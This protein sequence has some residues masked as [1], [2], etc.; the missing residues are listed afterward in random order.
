[1]KVLLENIHLQR[2]E[3]LKLRK[4]YIGSSEIGTIC[5]LNPYSSPLQLWR[6][7]T[8]RDSPREDNDFLWLGRRMEPVIG[9]LFEKRT[10]IKVEAA[11]TLYK[12]DSIEFASA[13]PDF[14]IDNRTAIVETKNRA[15]SQK[16]KYLDGAAPYTDHLQLNWQLGVCGLKSGYVAALVGASP[17]DF[18]T[19]KFEFSQEIFNQSLEL[20]EKFMHCVKTDTEPKA[21]AMDRDL[22]EATVNRVPNKTSQLPDDAKELIEGYTKAKKEIEKL[23]A[24]IKPYSD[25]L[26][27]CKARILQLMGDS[28]IGKWGRYVWTAKKIEKGSYMIKPHSYTLLKLKEEEIYDN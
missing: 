14:F 7:K 5:G 11:N 3:W 1:M 27:G 19:P 26:D 20:A 16:D 8:G 18:F 21:L 23:E 17:K 2:D 15:A 12:H 6:Y 10:G 4:N 9:E 25:L 28:S 24:E 13:S 22:I